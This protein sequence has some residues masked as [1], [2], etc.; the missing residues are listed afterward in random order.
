MIGGLLMAIV[1]LQ[2][3]FQLAAQTSAGTLVPPTLVATL[4]PPTALPALTTSS[5]ARMRADPAQLSLKI[6]ILYNDP[7]FAA[8][9]TGGQ[10]TGFSA[11]LGQAIA[12]DWGIP[13]ATGSPS[14]FV[15]V[16]RQNQLDLLQSGQID[17][18]MG[19]IVHTRALDKTLDFSDTIFINHQVALVNDD[20]P[21]KSINDLAGQTVGVVI[22]SEAET[23]I[24]S[25]QSQTKL[26]LKVTRLPLL[27]D[28][29]RMLLAHQ[30]A[31][32]IDDRWTLDQRVR[33]V[34]Q[35]IHLVDGSFADDPYA[36]AVRQHDNSLRLLINRSLQKLVKN[37][38]LG[39]IYAVWFPESILPPS[40]RSLPIPWT[41][42]STDGRSIADFTTD[43]RPPA[44]SVIEMIQASHTLRVVGIGAPDST[45]KLS[46][47]DSF[48]QAMI[49]EMAKRWGA[50]VQFVGSGAGSAEDLLASGG[51]DLAI[52]IEPH[53]GALPPPPSD[54]TASVPTGTPAPTPDRVDFVGV[55]AV[56][57]YRLM[58]VNGRGIA[59]LSDMFTGSRN[60]GVYTDDP[61]A[62]PTALAL[63]K[64]AGIDSLNKF[65]ISPGDDLI[66]EVAA[67]Q[68]S[69][70]FADSLRVVPYAAANSGVFGVTDK[71]YTRIP[72]AFAV[73]LNDSDFRA[74]VAETLQ[75][76]SRDGTYQS[77]FKA[78][79]NIG[80]PQPI[81]FWP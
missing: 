68:L 79:F 37:G 59:N 75:D 63:A 31:A 15:Q 81:D 76:M 20:S 57:G 50:T 7:P 51:A 28:G 45:G 38:Q 65:P 39:Q 67:G 22:G 27:D 6:G 72:L 4:P 19:P 54:S 10:L 16:T 73:P 18:L 13:T 62:F 26:T 30:L 48:D 33:T 1:A 49:N 70:V 46:L 35:G 25:W 47:L 41:G 77:I 60:L 12:Q 61:A 11:S 53:W 42:L 56:H 32:V 17:L 55:Y 3:S 29:I 21:A 34:I 14:I 23:A 52:G 66:G 44:K 69:A 8:L 40:Q 9:D 24:V 74:L 5:L 36:I 64:S 43:L 71:E 2:P 78:Q 58:T 80:S